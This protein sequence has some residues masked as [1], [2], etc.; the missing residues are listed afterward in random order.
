MFK[1]VCPLG[2]KIATFGDIMLGKAKAK[3]TTR[4]I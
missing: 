2:T 4:K 1:K 3:K